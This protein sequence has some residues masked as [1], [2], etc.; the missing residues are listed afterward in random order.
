MARKPRI[1]RFFAGALILIILSGC[2]STPPNENGDHETNIEANAPDSETPS[3]TKA[4]GDVFFTFVD[5]TEREIVL[6]ESP[7]R[8][9]VLSPQLLDLL[10]AVDG[11]AVARATASGGSVPKEA[12]NLEDVGGITTVNTEKL[13]ALNPDLVIGSTSFHRDLA[14]ILD[15]SGIPLA[16]FTL[17][18]YEDLKE[19][20]LL[21]GKLAGTESSAE[22]QL[23]A[24]D[25]KINEWV[26]QLPAENGPT[27]IMLNVAPSSVSVQRS[28]TVGL[29]VAEMLRMSNV[30]EEMEA[31]DSRPTTAPFS[32]EKIAELDPEFVFI[33]IHG[34]QEDGLNKIEAE[35]SSQ[36][37]WQSLR[38]VKEERM[39]VLP[40]DL[41]LSNPGFRLHESVEY[42][43]KLV[44]PESFG[45]GE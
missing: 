1:R 7:K 6:P 38:A 34:A 16:L 35:L 28:N 4:D 14:D 26:E 25:Q 17:S 40:S 27:F 30:A 21:M 33:L 2:A 9:V 29:E 15:A 44:Y 39:F 22:E 36:P 13:V 24:L 20:A 37:A 42:L 11:T 43:A 18:T 23:A 45:N 8:I 10:Y 3:D 32:L 19:K 12:E 41:L 31:S 5:D